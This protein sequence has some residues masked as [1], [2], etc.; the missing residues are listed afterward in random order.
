VSQFP[1]IPDI[2]R[3]YHLRSCVH[4]VHGTAADVIRCILVS[5]ATFAVA[6]AALVSRY[7]KPRLVARSVVDQLLKVPVSS[8]DKL[9]GLE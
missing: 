4:A 8:V 5:G 3:F 9:V 2:E 7:D 1:D 6:W